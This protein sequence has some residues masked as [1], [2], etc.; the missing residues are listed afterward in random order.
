MQVKLNLEFFFFQEEKPVGG[1]RYEM[2]K[3]QNKI[4]KKLKKKQVRGIFIYG[5]LLLLLFLLQT[6]H[7]L[8]LNL[9]HLFHFYSF[10]F[11][12]RFI[13]VI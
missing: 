4:T 8:H 1:K 3:I 7:S 2:K 13:I 12:L 9:I 5:L 11:L 10:L 6:R